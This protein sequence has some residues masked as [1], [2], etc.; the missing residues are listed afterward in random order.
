M[1]IHHPAF[2]NHICI[3]YI[4]EKYQITSRSIK[5]HRK[6]HEYALTQHQKTGIYH[7]NTV[8][9]HLSRQVNMQLT[10]QWKDIINQIAISVIS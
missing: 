8:H 4:S 10:S 3:M 9:T 5:N 2:K 1:P 6:S 7:Y